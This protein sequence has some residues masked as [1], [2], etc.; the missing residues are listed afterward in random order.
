[1]WAYGHH[2]H[3]EDVNNGCRTQHCGVEI[4]FDKSSLASHRDQNLMH[5]TLGYAKRI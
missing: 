2:F 5:G 3:M 4:M 1:M